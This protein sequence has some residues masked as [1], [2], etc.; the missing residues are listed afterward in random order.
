[1]FEDSCVD[2]G[3]GKHV[4]V[5]GVD[6]HLWEGKTRLNCYGSYEMW[7]LVDRLYQRPNRSFVSSCN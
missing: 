3:R 2:A 7:S 5:G 4:V 1:M 6:V